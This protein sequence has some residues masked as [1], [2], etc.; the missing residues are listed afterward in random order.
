MRIFKPPQSSSIRF[1]KGTADHWKDADELHKVLHSLPGYFRAVL[2]DLIDN[3]MT[4]EEFMEAIKNIEM[5]MSGNQKRKF[6]R[7]DVHKDIDFAI[8]C[9]VLEIIDG[10]YALTPGG[11]EIAQHMNE[12][13]PLFFNTVLSTKA[14]S[15]VTIIIHVLLSIVK[16]VFGFLSR[17]AGLIADGI[18][19]TVDTISSILVWFGIKYQRDKIVSLFIIIMM[20]ASVVGIVLTGINKM[21]HPLPVKEGFIAFI[22]SAISGCVM[23]LLSA[24]QYITGKKTANFAILCQSVDSRNH[25]LTSLL[26]CAGILTSYLANVF[27]QTWLYYSDA[28]VAMIIGILISKGTFELIIEFLKPEDEATR[29]PHFVEKARENMKMKVVYQWLSSELKENNMSYK[30][31][32]VRFEKQFCEQAP[33]IH[34]LTGIGYLPKTRD[35]LQYFLDTFNKKKKIVFKDNKYSIKF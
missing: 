4:Q 27:T 32:L 19:N 16:L 8:K 9:R 17:S 31:L 25:F 11:L 7:T 13:I 6:Q 1:R 28:I 20:A 2:L 26:V 12:V 14:V 24:Y 5:R 29:I 35:E 21:L 18:D 3:P 10:K 23:L 34:A 15:I 30:E 33:K 22:V